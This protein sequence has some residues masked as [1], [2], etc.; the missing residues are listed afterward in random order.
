MRC[1]GWIVCTSSLASATSRLPPLL[2]LVERADAAQQML[3]HRIVVIHVELH[4]RH[5]AAE[6]AHELAEHAG[7][8][9]APEHGLRRGLRGQDVEEQPVRLRVPAHLGVDQLERAGGGAHRF[10]MEREIVLLREV[11]Q[12]DQID[13]IAPE[14]VGAGDVDAVVVDG[15]VVGLAQGAPA[16]RRAQARDHAAEHRRRLGLALLE[17]GAEDGGEV[18]DVLGGEEIVLHEALDVLE[19]GCS[20]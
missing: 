15:E 12:P 5:D 14:D 13:R 9:H 8:V 18:A 1:R 7:L 10:G 20:V 3:V 19:P 6:G 4:H 17:A 2:D 16:A 11:K